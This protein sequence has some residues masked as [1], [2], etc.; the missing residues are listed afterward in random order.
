M[1]IITGAT[2]GIGEATARLAAQRGRS[3]YLL[4]RRTERL[5]KISKDIEAQYPVSA[6]W[7]AVDVASQASVDAW[8]ST[9]SAYFEQAEIL[10]NNAG[11]ARGLDAFGDSSPESWDEMIDTNLKGVL[12]LTHALLPSFKRRNA[13]HVINI[14]SVAGHWVYPK[15]HV[16]NASKFAVRA[17]TEALRMDLL[18]TGIRVTEISPGMVET[19]FSQVRFGDVEKARSVYAG[20]TPLTPTDVAEAILWAIERP[21]RVNIQ[22]I[23][24][25][26]TEQASPT[27]VHRS[28]Q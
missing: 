26:P 17:F 15:G 5:A 14:G 8:R 20:M 4:G 7:A 19:E 28:S 9:A 18:G 3:V 22:E 24:L 16:Y 21:A 1:I 25:Y 10:V 13:G 6:P 23:V 27:L 2:S 12:R 11:L